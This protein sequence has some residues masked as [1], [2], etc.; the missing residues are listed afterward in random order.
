MQ[1]SDKHPN[2]DNKVEKDKTTKANSKEK[3]A[4]SVETPVPPQVMDPSIEP[5]K[6]EH[7]DHVNPEKKAKDESRK[8]KSPKKAKGN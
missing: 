4:D 8:K 7:Q 5:G 1:N 6:G 3:D 2:T